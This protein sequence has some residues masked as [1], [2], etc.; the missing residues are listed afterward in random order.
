MKS[1]REISE[2]LNMN[3]QKVFTRKSNV[4]PPQRESHEV[5]MWKIRVNKEELLELLKNLDEK[6][7]VGPDE[8]SGHI[9][10]NCRQQI[11]DPVYDIIKCSVESG[12]VPKQ[13]KRA[14]IIPIHN[15]VNKE[16]P[17]NYRPVSLTS[18]VCKL[19]ERVIKKQWI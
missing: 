4:E 18:I 8:V 13:W 17:L 1:P 12:K 2:V 5:E 15:S 11:I 14:D 10:K 19:C 3:F 9:F 7:A 6:K 16:E